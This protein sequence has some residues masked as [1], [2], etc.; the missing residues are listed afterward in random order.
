MTGNGALMHS[1]VGSQIKDFLAESLHTSPHSISIT[2]EMINN[3]IKKRIVISFLMI[4][5]VFF[6]FG[7]KP[8]IQET[9]PAFPVQN[10]YA[11]VTSA[12]GIINLKVPSWINIDPTYDCKQA[13]SLSMQYWWYKKDLYPIGKPYAFFAEKK[14]QRVWVNVTGFHTKQEWMAV[15]LNHSKPWQFE[16]SVDHSEFPLEMYPK[17]FWESP[18]GASNHASNSVGWGVKNTVDPITKKPFIASCSILPTNKNNPTSAVNGKFAS[19]GDSKCMGTISAIKQNK[20]ITASVYVW[21]DS[22]PEIDLIF[23]SITKELTKFIQEE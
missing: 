14:H 2:P 18:S 21:A 23:N 4:A 22:A 12:G 3:M 13:R 9:C 19:Y 6:I 16:G 1:Y 10:G 17:Y 7:C 11:F 15:V 8:K 5:C 20:I